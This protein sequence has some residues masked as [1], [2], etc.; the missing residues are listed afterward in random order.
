MSGDYKKRIKLLNRLFENNSFLYDLATYSNNNYETLINYLSMIINY[1]L[2]SG[3]MTTYGDSVEMLISK[4]KEFDSAEIKYIMVPSNHAYLMH[5]MLH[6]INGRKRKLDDLLSLLSE[7]VSFYSNHQVSYQTKLFTDP[8]AAVSSTLDYPNIF[9]KDILKTPFAK[10]DINPEQSEKTYYQSILEDR[11]DNVSSVNYTKC[12][13]AARQIMNAFIPSQP[14]LIVIPVEDLKSI[15]DENDII[16]GESVAYIPSRYLSFLTLPSKYE[17]LKLCHK[18]KEKVDESQSEIRYAY[19]YSRFETITIDD[20]FKYEANGLTGDPIYDIDTIY[21]KGNSDDKS[22]D[23]D[24][25][26]TDN[27]YKIKRNHDINITRMNG[28]YRISN[29]RHRLLYLINTYIKFKQGAKSPA[30]IEY[31]KNLF[32][33][34]ARV[35]NHIEDKSFNAIIQSLGSKYRL[36]VY[37]NDIRNDE[38]DVY[39]SINNLIFHVRNIAEL[40]DFYAGINDDSVKIKYYVGRDINPEGKEEYKR[41]FAALANQLQERVFDMSFEQILSFIPEKNINYL[42]LYN[43]YRIMIDK[44]DYSRILGIENDYLKRIAQVESSSG[45]STKK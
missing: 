29:G 22:F 4:V 13:K 45:Y 18:E 12:A 33:I 41:L 31:L 10:E 3:D 36:G 28:Y 8:T 14:M 23:R 32:T 6:G 5:T 15:V 21:G 1:Y 34:P 35:V 17:L 27:I 11:L 25:S 38:A 9:F 16:Q 7:N 19:G 2:L 39:L 20:T 24:A 37:K 26:I 43:E 42:E 44:V 30:D 40:K